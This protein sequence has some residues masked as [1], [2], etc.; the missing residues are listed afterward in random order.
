MRFYTD[1]TEIIIPFLTISKFEYKNDNVYIYTTSLTQPTHIVYKID[2]EYVELLYDKYNEKMRNHVQENDI[3][4]HSD[5]ILT[6]AKEQILDN[7]ADLIST[8]IRDKVILV[9][10]DLEEKID[11]VNTNFQENLKTSSLQHN[12]IVE[13][14]N[15]LVAKV[16]KSM[17]S[18]DTEEI[19][20]NKTNEINDVGGNVLNELNSLKQELFKVTNALNDLTEGE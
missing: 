13:E 17:S 3:L 9:N 10:N 6:Q 19:F 18:Y 20:K 5:T 15:S 12:N 14:I 4:K 7:L 8:D 16:K 1:D 11:K 2:Y